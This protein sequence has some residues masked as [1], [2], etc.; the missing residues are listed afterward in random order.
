LC[1]DA[2]GRACELVIDRGFPAKIDLRRMLVSDGEG[3]AATI[4]DEGHC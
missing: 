4:T 2:L 1:L 3:C